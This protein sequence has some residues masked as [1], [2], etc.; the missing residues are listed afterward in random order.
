MQGWRRSMEDAH[1]TILDLL[2]DESETAPREERI[3]F[4]GVYDG[5]GGKRV[6]SY[7][8]RNIHKIVASQASFKAK[9]YAQGL[10]DGFLATDRAILQD[11]SYRGEIS[12]C[13]ATVLLVTSSTVFVANAGDSRAV[14]GI[15][16][17]AKPLSDDHK[18]ELDA[19]M[20]RI[21]A[22]GGF[23]DVGRVNG[24]LA[25][26]RAIGD[27][28]Y[29]R[30][31][32]LPPERQ[33]I[34]AFPDVIQHDITADDEFL[35]LACD[36][37]WDCVDSQAAVEFVRRGIAAYQPLENIC[38]DLMNQCMSTGIEGIGYDNMT[39]MVVGLLQGKNEEEWYTMIAARV[40]DGDGS[41]PPPEYAYKIHNGILFLWAPVIT[42]AAM[43][44]GLTKPG[45]GRM[46][47]LGW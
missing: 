23:V 45:R 21:V 22:A 30:N 47:I 14:L 38:E 10:R 5:H 44:F 37:I 19:E 9:N 16:G 36:G 11:R 1:T 12:G 32:K 41:C 27:F 20:E 28:Q 17:R 40:A 43:D 26:S 4:F 6:A 3:S 35:V 46:I 2:E 34:T 15:K 13:T 8:G 33:I 24:I 31:P 25:V 42:I 39:M 29:K 18:P 7:S